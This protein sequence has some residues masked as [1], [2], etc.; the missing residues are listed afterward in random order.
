MTATTNKQIMTAIF[1]K[2]GQGDGSLFSEH[3][4]DDLPPSA[5]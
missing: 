5:A 4:S 3:L 1:D 2:V